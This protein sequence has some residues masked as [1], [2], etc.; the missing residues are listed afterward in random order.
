VHTHAPIGHARNPGLLAQEMAYETSQKY[1]E[2]KYIV[3]KS[4][5]IKLNGWM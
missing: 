2:G 1:K 4:K 3:E 5:I